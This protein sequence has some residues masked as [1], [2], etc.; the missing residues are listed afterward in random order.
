M[1][2]AAPRMDKTEAIRSMTSMACICEADRGVV[3][4][5]M[6][7]E[8]RDQGQQNRMLCVDETERSKS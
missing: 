6:V 8:P 5:A 2:N 1:M 3:S 4:T 7:T